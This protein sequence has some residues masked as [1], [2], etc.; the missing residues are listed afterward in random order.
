MM[1]IPDTTSGDTGPHFRSGRGWSACTL[2]TAPLQ[3]DPRRGD[4]SQLHLF[5]RS[6]GLPVARVMRGNIVGRLAPASKVMICAFWRYADRWC[7]L[8]R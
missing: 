5:M 3:P 7:A 4:G 6:V 1:T 8:S 2:V